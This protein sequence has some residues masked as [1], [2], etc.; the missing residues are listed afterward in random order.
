MSWRLSWPARCP[1]LPCRSA[2]SS[3]HS[4]WPGAVSEQHTFGFRSRLWRAEQISLH[5]RAAERTQ[6][7]L[8]P[9]RFNAL[10]RGRH[11]S[12]RGDVH[13]RLHNGGSARFGDIVDE[14][15]IDLDFVERKT[16]QIAQ[17]GIAGSEIV[18]RDPHPDGAKLVKN[19]QAAMLLEEQ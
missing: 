11:M 5:F 17:R 16:L 13:H 12:R 19:P 6:Q 3:G 8:L 18:Q 1:P 9:L 14:A 7:F 2:R 15:A 10:R 4:R